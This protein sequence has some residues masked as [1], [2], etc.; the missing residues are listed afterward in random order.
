MLFE[1]SPQATLRHNSLGSKYVTEARRI[2]EEMAVKIR[3]QLLQW[4]DEDRRIDIKCFQRPDLS[5]AI[6]IETTPGPAPKNGIYLVSNDQVF[7]V[8]GSK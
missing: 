7:F 8:E 6:I 5:H 1:Q 3:E 4:V 2:A